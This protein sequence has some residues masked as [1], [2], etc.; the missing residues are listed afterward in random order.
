VSVLQVRGNVLK[1]VSCG[2]T[3]ENRTL[4]DSFLPQIGKMLLALVGRLFLVVAVG[5]DPVLLLLRLHSSLWFWRTLELWQPFVVCVGMSARFSY[6][7][8]MAPSFENMNIL[9]LWGSA[10]IVSYGDQWPLL[11][12]CP[13]VT[14]SGRRIVLI[15]T[16]TL[17]RA[18]F[19]PVSGNE[20]V[21]RRT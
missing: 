2:R 7:H 11:L 17:T 16:E 6:G 14:Q 4:W 10:D 13:D 12:S 3:E 8:W 5:L 1:V 18:I 15:P 20:I 21:W 19:V 9:R